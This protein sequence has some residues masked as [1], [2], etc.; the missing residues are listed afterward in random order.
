MAEDDTSGMVALVPSSDDIA[1][2]AVD[3]G[4][5]PE[6]LHLTL[7][8]LGDD[9]TGWEPALKASLVAAMRKLADKLGPVPADVFAHAVF[10]PNGD[11]FDPATVY[12]VNG[13][14]QIR[15]LVCQLVERVLGEVPPTFPTYIPHVTA[16]YGLP[17]ERLAYTGPVVFDR[18]RVALGSEVHDF[19]L[20]V[21]LTLSNTLE[22][23]KNTG[24]YASSSTPLGPGDLW[25]TEGL[26]LPHYIRNVARGIMRQGKSKSQ[27]IRL[28][29]AA[30]KRWARGGSDVSPEVRAAAAKALAAWQAARAKAKATPNKRSDHSSTAVAMDLAND[31]PRVP[32]GNASAGQFMAH[33]RE[34]FPTEPRTEPVP[35]ISEGNLPALRETLGTIDGDRMTREQRDELARELLLA[36]ARVAS[37]IDLA[38]DTAT[39]PVVE[40]IY[41]RLRAKGIPEERA[42]VLAEQAAKRAKTKTPGKT[43]TL[44]GDRPT[45]ELATPPRLRQPARKAAA[46]EGHALP[47][48]SFPMRTRAELADAIRAWGRAVAAGKARQVK[49]LMLKRARALGVSPKVTDQIKALKG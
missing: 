36:A 16:G 18:L 12:L 23:S 27:A 21:T 29:V 10:N 2:L 47:D 38:S 22:M 17:F 19:P 24:R 11:R 32:A 46:S 6:E 5:P 49:A 31:Q 42:R 3:G 15:Q 26:E 43:A 25:K 40:K 20:G 44:S 8:Y 37:P 48:G 39:D 41:R 30:V 33:L 14:F 7:R 9:V 35:T 4:D 34:D 28:A 1:R 45:V 13:N